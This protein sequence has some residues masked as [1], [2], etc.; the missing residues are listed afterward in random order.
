[1]GMDNTRRNHNV[2]E[3][4][5]AG[6]LHNDTWVLDLEDIEKDTSRV[7]CKVRFSERRSKSDKNVF[8]AGDVLYGNFVRI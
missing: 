8:A 2:G 4:V 6:T 3:T 5:K 7:V 1:M